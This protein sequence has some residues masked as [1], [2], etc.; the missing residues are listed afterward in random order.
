MAAVTRGIGD[1]DPLPR[2]GPGLAAEG[3]LS[4][5]RDRKEFAGR[6]RTSVN[7]GETAF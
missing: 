6:D 7:E 5:G 2:S 1:V 3:L 4:A